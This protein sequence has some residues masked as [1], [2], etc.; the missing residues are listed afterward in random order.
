MKPDKITKAISDARDEDAEAIIAVC[1]KKIRTGADIANEITS[2]EAM[3]EP[4]LNTEE[5]KNLV[6]TGWVSLD[7]L[8][9]ELATIIGGIEEAGYEHPYD[10]GFYQG[11][12]SIKDLID[13]LEG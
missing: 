6:G 8:K 12:M 10:S 5:Y 4:S 1:V 13:E 11:V 7:W 3:H 9:N 2:Y